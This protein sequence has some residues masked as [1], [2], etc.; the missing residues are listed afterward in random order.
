ANAGPVVARLYVKAHGA[1]D[2]LVMI[3]SPK[4]ALAPGA[5]PTLRWTVE[6]PVG[7]LIGRVGVQL[8]SEGRAEG[9][10]YLDWLTWEGAPAVAFD[11]PAHHG[12]LWRDAW[13]QACSQFITGRE[14]TYRIIQD[15]G[16]GLI[17]QGTREWRDY[18]VRA[19]L[20]PHLARSFG[21]AVR[22]QGLRRYYALRLATGGVAQ[23]VRELD[24]THI[25]AEAPC[26][27]S[28]Y[29][30]YD[31]ELAV[32]GQRL[33]GSINGQ[34]LFDLVDESP[35]TGGAIALLVEEGRLGANAV[36]VG[37]VAD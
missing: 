3:Q 37:P 28:L 27:W 20:T 17:L 9:S 2:A 13:V 18:A 26:A 1:D 31:F 16:T 10:V 5:A 14:Q 11:P 30:T 19:E 34:A 23:L 36:A 15:E 24:G 25:L 12:T 21:V 8:T 29:E 6:V 32:Q 35:L 7:C 4:Q 22:G 33:R